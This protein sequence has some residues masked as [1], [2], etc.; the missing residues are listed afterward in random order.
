L[1]EFREDNLDYGKKLI[2]TFDPVS[3]DAIV[4]K[5]TSREFFNIIKTSVD[6]GDS[7]KEIESKIED[8]L[9]SS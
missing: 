4:G 2:M 6:Q 5:M 1:N 3:P 8:F 9:R 7:K